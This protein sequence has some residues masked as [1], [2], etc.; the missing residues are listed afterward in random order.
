MCKS[1]R[2]K[3]R[4]AGKEGPP[5]GD[6]RCSSGCA[7]GKDLRGGW[8]RPQRFV[9]PARVRACEVLLRACRATHRARPDSPPRARCA[10]NRARAVAARSARRQFQVAR[11]SR[12]RWVVGG[13]FCSGIR[14]RQ[15]SPSRS[16]R[17]TP[18]VS[19]QRGGGGRAKALRWRLVSPEASRRGSCRL[20]QA[21]RTRPDFEAGVGVLSGI[22]RL[23]L[24]RPVSRGQESLLA[25]GERWLGLPYYGAALRRAPPPRRSSARANTRRFPLPARGR[26]PAPGWRGDNLSVPPLRPRGGT[27]LRETAARAAPR[28]APSVLG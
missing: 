1:G 14:A 26:V 6:H 7:A 18:K 19:A 23:R 3:R 10:D 17:W 13:A 20:A 11:V 9:L 27:K 12:R 8:P 4:C 22:R 2:K 16:W 24:G 25:H 15:D 21:F 28:G 5:T